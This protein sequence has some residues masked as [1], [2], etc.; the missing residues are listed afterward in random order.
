MIV[1]APCAMSRP[2]AST[3]R[4][5]A[6]TMVRPALTTRPSAR[7]IP[8]SGRISRREIG[9]GFDGR[10]ACAGRQRRMGRP[11]RHAFDQ[12]HRKAGVDAAQRVEQVGPRL[13]LE[14]GEGVADLDGPHRKRPSYGWDGQAA[15]DHR[16]QELAAGQLRHLLLRGDAEFLIRRPIHDARSRLVV[17]TQARIGWRDEASAMTIARAGA[18]R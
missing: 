17:A 7:T 4:P 14:N 16:L 18:D 13:A 1:D 8:V 15:V 9:L 2:R 11:G 12:R 10:V 6:E 3:I 5:T